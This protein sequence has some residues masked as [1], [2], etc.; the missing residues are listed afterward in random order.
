MCRLALVDW[1]ICLKTTAC[2]RDFMQTL[3]QNCHQAYAIQ[4]YIKKNKLVVQTGTVNQTPAS[5]SHAHNMPYTLTVR[6][7]L[8][9][10]PFLLV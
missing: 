8:M 9:R 3:H 1:P 6:H 2:T 5:W 10:G 4:H 7:R